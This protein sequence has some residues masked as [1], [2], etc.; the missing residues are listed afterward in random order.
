MQI[1]IASGRW[2]ELVQHTTDEW[3]NRE[4]RTANELLAAGELAQAVRAPHA[5]ALITAATAKAPDDPGVL[6]GAYFH[7]INAGWEEDEVTAKWLTTAAALSGDDGPIKSVS[8]KELVERQP[9]WDK[10]EASVSDQLNEGKIPVFG[11]AHILNRSLTDFVLLPSLANLNERDPRRRSIVYAYSGAR[12]PTTL[13]PKKVALDLAAII[14][15]ARLHLLETV[16]A[17][18]EIVIPHSTLGWLFHERQRATFH[19]PSR[20][21]DAHNLKRLIAEGALQVLRTQTPPDHAIAKEVGVS[22]AGLLLTAEGR[23]QAGDG[24]P[25]YVVRSSPVYRTGSLL[26]EE[27]DLTAYSPY[28]CSCH[29]LVDKLRARGFLTRTEEQRALAYL[30]L[31]ERRWPSE[32]A[33]ADGA[34]LFLDDV[35]VSHL[36]TIGV[37]GRLKAAGLTAY[38]SESEDDDS[39]RLLT[40][41]NLSTQQLEVIETIRESLADGLKSG[42]VRA[43]RSTQT[44]DDDN[45]V[46]MHPTFAIL[47]IESEVDAFVVDDRFVNR[48][49]TIDRNDRRTP[50]LSTLDVMDDLDGRQL[51]SAED[52]FSRRTYLRQAGYQLVSVTVDELLHHL[53]NAPLKDGQVVE[54]A[55][56][57]AIRESLLKGRMSKML[58]IPLETPWLHQTMG[59]VMGCIKQ[60]WKIKTE[61]AEAMSYSEWLLGLLDVRG[62]APSALPGNERGFALFAFAAHVHSLMTAPDGVTDEAKDTY[63]N[64][65]DER[66]VKNVRDT[67]PEAFAWIVERAREMIS[68]AADEAADAL[69]AMNVT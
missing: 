35:S 5:R 17:A 41:E 7:S 57:R 23:T 66:L 60:L 51:I 54:T 64:W 65:V 53:G 29:A 18:Y 30:K 62:W 22:L 4:K 59:S 8:M 1:A 34:E 38:V 25:C 2:H 16:K 26:E 21:R 52:L 20:I 47:S 31:H 56:L 42:R 14:T 33:I 11:A 63:R 15:F 67:Q 49:L 45:P 69:G 58:Q 36:R 37:L 12:L 50:I 55:E 10:R 27:A 24:I 9:E 3:N 39:N 6:A 28:L 61:R 32:P 19:Q 13:K 40:F 44:E 48:Y 43:V 46:K 68:H